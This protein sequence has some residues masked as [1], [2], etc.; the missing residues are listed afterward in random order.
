VVNA[1]VMVGTLTQMPVIGL[2]LDAYWQ[3]MA[4]NGVRQYSLEA[5]QVALMLLAGWMA[6]SFALLLLTRETHARQSSA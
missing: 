4:V 6:V 1:G 2:I 5:F 3:G